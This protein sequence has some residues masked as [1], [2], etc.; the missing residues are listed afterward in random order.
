MKK[1]LIVLTLLGLGA[2]AAISQERPDRRTPPDPSQMAQRRV[3]FLTEKLSLTVE[4]QAQASAIFTDSAKSQQGTREALM[5]TREEIRSQVK[6]G[7]SEQIDALATKIGQLTA[8]LESS[9]AKTSI[10]FQKI[11]TPDQQKE[12]AQMPGPG[13][14]HGFPPG[15]PPPGRP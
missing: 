7:Q 5:K 15:P 11:L 9:E 12:F 4:Q 6:S 2:L 1:I 3:E 10:A 14:D 8:Q 13:F